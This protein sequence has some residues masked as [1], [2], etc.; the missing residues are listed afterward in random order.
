VI[1]L[2][3]EG[4]SNA[5]RHAKASTIAVSGCHLGADAHLEI[6]SNG[7]GMTEQTPGL[8]TKLFNELTSSYSYSRQGDWNLL[9]FSVRSTQLDG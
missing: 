3:D 1:A 4:V 2:I 7:S 5:I 8:G 6:L 9:K